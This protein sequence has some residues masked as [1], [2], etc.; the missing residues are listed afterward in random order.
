MLTII[1]YGAG[2]I[3]SIRNMLKKIGVPSIIT[4]DVEEVS[5]AEKLIIPGVGHYS[6]GMQKLKASGLVEELSSKVLNDKV[7][8]LGICLGAQLLGNRSEESDEKGLGWLDMDVVKF[9]ASQM[10]DSLR[11]PHMG[12]SEVKGKKE[13]SL[14]KGYDEVPR[15][16]FVHTYHMKTKEESDILATTE[17]GYEFISAVEKDNIFGVQ[18]HPEKSHKFGMQLLKNFSKL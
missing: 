9:N 18:F 12:W 2:N 14:L 10:D 6:Y 1:D 5:K 8:I 16:Y 4:S 3:K 7:P 15:F 13:S 17:Y 11:I